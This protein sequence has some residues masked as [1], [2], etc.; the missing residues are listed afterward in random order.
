MK[1]FKL[2][3]GVE[4]KC[5][6]KSVFGFEFF[7]FRSPPMVKEMDT[8]LWATRG[9]S[10]LLDIGAFHGVYSLAFAGKI[11]KAHAIDPS[12]IAFEDLMAN[13]E[14]NRG[15]TIHRCALSNTTGEMDMVYEWEHAVVKTTHAGTTPRITAEVMTGDDYCAMR[16]FYPDVI[17]IDVEGHEMKVLQG[18][19]NILVRGRVLAFIEL[20]PEHIA[21]EGDTLEGIHEFIRNK[22]FVAYDMD[23]NELTSLE[24]QDRIYIK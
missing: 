12:P 2:R 11:R 19:D 10:R 18:L 21:L 3:D 14:A 7:T 4:F 5:T 22:N 24:G 1:D 16:D 17:K 6:E 23:S 13:A 15:I 8:F 20:H 9:C